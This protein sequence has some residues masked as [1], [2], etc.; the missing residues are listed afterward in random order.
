MGWLPLGT[1]VPDGNWTRID[2]PLQSRLIRVQY[3]G[4]AAW[5]EKYNPRLYFRL[6]IDGQGHTANWATLWPKDGQ[7]ELFEM[8]GPPFDYNY[9]EFRKQQSFNSLQASYQIFLEQ[10][11]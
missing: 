2:Q 9:L 11:V 5:L 10:F 8:M 6:W 3:W 7:T 4:D 1:F